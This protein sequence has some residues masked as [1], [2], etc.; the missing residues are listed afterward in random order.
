[1]LIAKILHFDFFRL[2]SLQPRKLHSHQTTDEFL[3]I[4]H[5]FMQFLVA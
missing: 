3:G 5:K 4:S 2:K 1:M